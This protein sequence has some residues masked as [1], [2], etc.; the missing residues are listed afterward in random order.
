MP[1]LE[2]LPSRHVIVAERRTALTEEQ[3]L[4]QIQRGLF[5]SEG[6][7]RF[8]I[9]ADHVKRRGE[10]L[11]RELWKNDAQ[12]GVYRPGVKFHPL[13][14]N[15]QN[16]ALTWAR[17]HV[18]E[19]IPYWYYML[20]LGH[21]LHVSTW[22]NLY[23]HQWHNGW[24]DP[25]TEETT[26]PIDPNFTSLMATH[27][28][29]HV[30]DLAQCPRDMGIT[31]ANF[32]VMLQGQ[33]GFV[34]NLGLLSSNK[35]TTAF[36]T[37]EIASL[38]TLP[39]LYEDFDHAEVGTSAAAEANTETTLVATSGIARVAGTPTD[40]DPIYR[41]VATITADVTETWEE[42]GLF[43]ASSSG[44]MM[45]RTLTLGQSVNNT[46]Q[47]QYTYELTKNAEA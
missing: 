20:T 35:V 30:C 25:F 44:T 47:V 31:Q 13:H 16:K 22:A 40:V 27:Y 38:V 21:D 17:D 36:V 46:D 43:N 37:F 14:F 23:A 34:E 32:L 39:T 8:A 29:D 1:V 26:G 15:I 5:T 41:S 45:D 7:E 4:L 19:R 10:F 2:K 3:R 33:K 9:P 18:D 11:H 12:H 6:G 28:V 42:H 24:A